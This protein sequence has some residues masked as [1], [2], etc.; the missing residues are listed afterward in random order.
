MNLCDDIEQQL[1]E[2]GLD[3]L[4][5]DE[6]RRHIEHCPRC[7]SLIARLQ[8]LESSL[9]QLP[10]HH[11][12]T[13]LIG[14]TK[15][16]IA[17]SKAPIK[18]PDLR[19]QRHWAA[20]LATAALVV[21]II[22]LEPMTHYRQF[23]PNPATS[24]LSSTGLATSWLSSL[25]EAP[26]PTSFA[27]SD[28]SGADASVP[29]NQEQFG[30]F[31]TPSTTMP[32]S[33]AEPKREYANSPA[34]QTLPD[35]ELSSMDKDGF[36]LRSTEQALEKTPNFADQNAQIADRRVG[37]ATGAADAL[38]DV[39][40]EVQQKPETSE[41]FYRRTF[42]GGE[43]TELDSTLNL[44][45]TPADIQAIDRLRERIGGRADAKTDAPAEET[46]NSELGK[47]K[48]RNIAPAKHALIQAQAKAEVSSGKKSIP[49]SRAA[50]PVFSSAQDFLRQ[51]ETLD[52][53]SFQAATGYWTN[54]YIPG[55][56][57]I[58][59]LQ[60]QVF[61]GNSAAPSLNQFIKTVQQPFDPPENAALALYLQ[62]DKSAIEGPSRVRLQV[63]LKGALRRA[64]Q[65]PALNIGVV[66]D[67]RGQDNASYRSN[68]HALL[69]ALAQTKQ[70]GDRFSLTVAGP[71]GGLVL[72][73]EQFRYGPLSLALNRLLLE[74]SSQSARLGLSAALQRA[75]EHVAAA[76]DPNA[77]LGSSM[78]LLIPT[79]PVGS[80][81][82][83]LERI[84]HNNAVQ[85][86]QLSALT[87]G[88]YSEPA[89]L[90][91][92]VLSGQGN[93]RSIN[94]PDQAKTVIEQELFSSSRAVARALRLRIRLAPDVKLIDIL[95]AY[96]LDEPAVQKVREAEQ[97]IDRRLSRNLGIRADRGE[98]EEGI[99]I[100]IPQFLAEAEHVILLDVLAPGSGPVAD[101]RLRYKDLVYGRNNSASAEHSL[102]AGSPTLG[103]LERNV[104]KNQ[105]A[106]Q[107]TQALR[108]AADFVAQNQTQQA[109]ATMAKLRLLL[110]EL[111]Q[112]FPAWRND[113]E[114]LADEQLLS[115]YINK[116]SINKMSSP[117]I[118][119]LR[120]T[121]YQKLL[122]GSLSE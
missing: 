92:L 77:P 96:R 90:Q 75:S 13:A 118:A 62:A 27:S 102:Q 9:G 52:N 29:L 111:R 105:L 17:Q 11:P 80:E 115:A 31:K 66:L 51:R 24:G 112:E 110:Q 59:R 39:R 70:A 68:I 63:G 56:P 94:T 55:D 38:A 86:I 28:E 73:P 71:A 100:V 19:I 32:E 81:L 37:Q 40:Q 44:P 113:P 47:A 18:Q 64:G 8:K 50:K 53:L 85:G 41:S 6:R 34:P 101:V 93:L 15:T 20:I 87:M 89:A 3:G 26:Q 14:K 106:F 74:N 79:A 2:D 54:T 58:R 97:S 114:L 21:A 88:A 4:H 10:K 107:F 116:I 117:I 98:D 120:Y 42:V 76:D 25:S 61:G 7:Q 95:G 82:A 12:P 33:E 1:L 30:F 16:T 84:A 45:N 103:P 67:L 108:Q 122:G 23:V 109:L 49:T 46:L 72:P 78:L 91:T 36:S 119:A 43:L 57:L 48:E 121:A 65:R 104:I 35:S 22:G 69:N 99:Q 5:Q 60:A 83:E